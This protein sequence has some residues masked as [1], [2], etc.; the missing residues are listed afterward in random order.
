MDKNNFSAAI[1]VKN[2]EKNIE[3]CIKSVLPFCS[4]VVVVDTG[5]TD[6]TPILASKLGAEIYFHKWNNSFSESR[7]IALNYARNKWI[8]SIDADETLDFS[9]F[10]N[11][12]KDE[13][14]YL[15]QKIGG[16]SINLKNYL[17][18][19]LETFS[20][21]RFT[22]IFINHKNIKFQ[23]NVHE[24]ITS[25][26]EEN[27]FEI[28]TS[29]IL[30]HHF[31]YIEKSAEKIQRNKMLL[32]ENISKGV[33]VDYDLYHLAS[34]EFAANNIQ[35]AE[36]LFEKLLNSNQLSKEQIAMVRVK[37]GQIFLQKSEY[38]KVNTILDFSYDD[39]NLEG[40]RQSVLASAKLMQKDFHAAQMLYD[41]FEIN[42][43]SMVD[44]AIIKQAKEV[45]KKISYELQ[46][47]SFQNS[48]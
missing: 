16:I 26:I 34:T 23:R 21:H 30:F 24:Q 3:K 11:F 40:L 33:D 35:V 48:Y 22:R 39:I 47:N 15:N 31:G 19:K 46:T 28:Y 42:N 45:L 27:N 7:N 18:D 5:S 17:D 37:L 29:N 32:E 4:Q 9:S 10:N 43:S 8:I 20:L 41:K 12:L 44:S 1:I 25:S 2:E 14:P 6:R 38:D 13:F 36:K